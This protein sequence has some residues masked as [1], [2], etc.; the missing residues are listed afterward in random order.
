MIQLSRDLFKE[1]KK[2]S[3]ILLDNHEAGRTRKFFYRHIRC[4]ILL[5]GGCQCTFCVESFS[6]T[7]SNCEEDDDINLDWNVA[8]DD[9]EGINLEQNSM[10]NVDVPDEHFPNVEKPRELQFQ[11]YYNGYAICKLRC[12]KCVEAMRSSS[13]AL[14]KSSEALILEKNFKGADDLR[15]MKMGMYSKIFSKHAERIGIRQFMLSAIKKVVNPFLEKPSIKP[16][17]NCT[18]N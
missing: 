14:G 17:A 2:V 3:F 15:R 7:G 1:D 11:R 6:K 12:E 8:Q 5:G 4:N 13:N 18:V 10:E 9:E 16:K